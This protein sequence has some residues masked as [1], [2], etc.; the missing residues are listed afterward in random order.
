MKE[1]YMAKSSNFDNGKFSY[2]FQV[3][4]IVLPK[5]LV[6]DIP[7]GKGICPLSMPG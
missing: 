5:D 3:S 2:I 6:L 1:F 7:F 4:L